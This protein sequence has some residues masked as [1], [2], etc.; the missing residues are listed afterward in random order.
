MPAELREKCVAA[1]GASLVDGYGLTE[2]SGVVATNP[3]DGPVKAGTIGQP[4]PA[5]RIRLLDK[6][7]PARDPRPGQPGE[8]AG[9]GPQNMQ[10]SWDRTEAD[11]DSFHADGWMRTTAEKG[12]CRE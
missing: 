10:G 11:G 8:L 9:N 1:T 6:E 5:T 7:D 4:I 2:S 3:Y 12:R